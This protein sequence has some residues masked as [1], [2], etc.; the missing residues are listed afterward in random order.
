ML[1]EDMPR[2]IRLFQVRISYV[3]RF[4][5]ICDLFTDSPSYVAIHHQKERLILSRWRP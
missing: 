5:S 3:L 1:M 2:N 4:M